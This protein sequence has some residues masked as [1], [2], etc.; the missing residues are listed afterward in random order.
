[1]RVTVRAAGGTLPHS[2]GGDTS[3]PSQVYFEGMGPL[4][5]KAA[6]AIFMVVPSYRKGNSL[7]RLV[8][9]PVGGR[10]EHSIAKAGATQR[11]HSLGGSG[12][13]YEVQNHVPR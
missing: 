6:L 1:M 13:E 3:S 12:A 4:F 8:C 11:A 5:S 7:A 10:S 2:S 9:Y